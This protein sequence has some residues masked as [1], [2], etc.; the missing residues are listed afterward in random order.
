MAFE[1][2]K[3]SQPSVVKLLINSMKKERLSH[4]Y[5]FEGEEGTKK[6]ETALYFAQML[7]CTE[8]EKPCG[9]CHNCRRVRHLTH[10]NLYVV[11]PFKNSIRKQQI[12]DLQN[13]FS[14]TSVEEGPKIYIIKELDTINISA[15]N[16]LLKFL[17]EPHPN[18]Y[19]ILTTA[20]IHRVLPTIISRS[21]VVQFSSLDKSLIERDLIDEG[22]P[23]EQAKIASLVSNRLSDALSL[24]SD[25]FFLET[26]ELVKELYRMLTEVKDSLV[27]HLHE[28]GEFIFQSN[29]SLKL[30]LSIMV[31]HQKDL[32][33]VRMKYTQAVVFG[34]A[35]E[36]SKEIVS[37]KSKERITS[38][39]EEMLSLT[40]RLNHYI[41]QRLAIDNLLIA[42]ERR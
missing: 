16:S 11:E 30:F 3:S 39:L 12:I 29:E 5:L 8:E 15:A 26:I 36:V 35:L 32:L 13:E 25:D 34:D 27:T 2:I 24:L 21:Q 19:A 38:E 18:T 7:L 10:P 4:A 20:N 40:S 14:K 1:K 37:R 23:D 41:N 28:H 6:F 42:L 22:Y 33:H 17:E 9:E 31:L